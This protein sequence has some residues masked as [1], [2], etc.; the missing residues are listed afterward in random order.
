MIDQCE[1]SSGFRPI[2][3]NTYSDEPSDLVPLCI[4][5]RSVVLSSRSPRSSGPKQRL[6]IRLPKK[7]AVTDAA[8][9]RPFAVSQPSGIAP[10][11]RTMRP[12]ESHNDGGFPV[13]KDCSLSHERSLAFSRFVCEDWLLNRD[14]AWYCGR[15][16]DTQPRFSPH[17]GM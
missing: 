9:S 17:L 7:Y 10:N 15:D 11:C 3:I 12:I 5:R 4:E 13:K 6:V 14:D 1:R 16:L 2:Q 8:L